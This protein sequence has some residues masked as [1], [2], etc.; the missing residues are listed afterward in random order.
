MTGFTVKAGMTAYI[1]VGG[2]PMVANKLYTVDL[3]RHELG[4]D[5]LLKPDYYE[6]CS[7]T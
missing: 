1:E 2:V 6:V 7:P 4:W 5:G 3:L